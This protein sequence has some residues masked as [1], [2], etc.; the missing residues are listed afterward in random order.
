MRFGAGFSG[1][2]DF[3]RSGTGRLRL[4]SRPGATSAIAF[5][6]P[7]THVAASSYRPPARAHGSAGQSVQSPVRQAWV[8]YRSAESWLPLIAVVVS[9]EMLAVLRKG[10]SW[11][12]P[13]WR[14]NNAGA[15]K[16]RWIAGLDIV[17]ATAGFSGWSCSRSP[18]LRQPR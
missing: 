6:E 12:F 4:R 10:F 9:E 14:D 18:R 5:V 8:S 17:E 1:R 3:S 13:I 11:G 15:K 2:E 7:S 16:A